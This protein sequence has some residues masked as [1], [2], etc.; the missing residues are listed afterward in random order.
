MNPMSTSRSFPLDFWIM[1]PIG[2][3]ASASCC[4][5]VARMYQENSQ[6]RVGMNSL[7]FS[8]TPFKATSL[9]NLPSR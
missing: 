6:M 5:T 3:M 2:T 4:D 1:A 9:N 7:I 8:N